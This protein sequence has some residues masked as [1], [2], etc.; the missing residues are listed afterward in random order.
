M[1]AA[2]LA[3]SIL[4]FL[5]VSYKIAKGTYEIYESA[6]GA[7][8]ENIHVSNVITDL[9]KA[10]TNLGTV[11]MSQDAELSKL[12]EKC[13][14]LSTDLLKLLSGLERR[15][16]KVFES[17][18]AAIAS[19]RKQKDIASIE[20][21]LEQYRQQII[22]HVSLNIYR[23]QSPIKIQL[24]RIRDDSTRFENEHAAKLV[25]LHFQLSEVLEIMRRP[26]LRPSMNNQVPGDRD[27][28][29]T[30]F[31]SDDELRRDEVTGASNTTTHDPSIIHQ[32]DKFGPVDDKLRDLAKLLNDFKSCANALES[33]NKTLGILYF[34]T[35]FQREDSI[36]TTTS[37]TFAWIVEGFMPSHNSKS[38]ETA[39]SYSSEES[40]PSAFISPPGLDDEELLDHD[41]I[42]WEKILLAETHHRRATSRSLHSFLKD[43]G[44]VFF[45]CGKAGS[46]KST[47][48][49]F[50]G[51]HPSVGE[52]LAGC[53][54]GRKLVLVNMFFWSSGD[55]LQKSLEGFYRTILFHTLSQCPELLEMVFPNPFGIGLF[56]RSAAMPLS[57]L[58]AAF[59]RLQLLKN[60]TSYL[61]CY[62][63]D[64]LDEYEGD[65]LDQK[66]LAEMLETWARADNVKIICSARPST[67]NLDIFGASKTFFEL[68]HLTKADIY[69]F[70]KTRFEEYLSKPIF[71]EGRE[72]CLGMVQT[73][74]AR[75]DGV[76][77]WASLVVRALLNAALEHED[78]FSIRRRLKECPQSLNQLFHQMLDSVDPSPSPLMSPELHGEPNSSRA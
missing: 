52:T 40:Q 72:A 32:I 66:R 41:Y 53:A 64:G 65:A 10:V 9:E 25:A 30:H 7:T 4:T 1:E 42:D 11:S 23:E 12:S 60:T 20:K 5:D 51:R 77:L 68:H 35:I 21:R 38:N 54:N 36:S 75:A 24:E 71:A 58:E 55:S 62:F 73:I 74:V 67:V 57:E 16:Q 45:I 31:H 49:K 47:L 76:F 44:E 13:R 61:F 3:S 27:Y 50:L 19:A 28:I 46:G 56:T 17:F 26:D 29:Q 22:L 15:E 14:A 70:S 69:A 43:E 48:M 39:G 63:I 2:G 37:D 78:K 34:D 18:K 33:E 59:S 6:T 8:A